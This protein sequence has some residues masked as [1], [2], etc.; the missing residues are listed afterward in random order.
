MN[1]KNLWSALCSGLAAATM[2]AAYVSLDVNPSAAAGCGPCGGAVQS[3]VGTGGGSTCTEAGQNAYN[4]A[5]AKAYAGA[6]QETPCQLTEG[7]VSSCIINDCYPGP[8]SPLYFASK[9][10]RFKTKSCTFP[11][12]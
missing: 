3:V 2:F 11:S 12:P 8:C 7:A 6:P 4:D 10:L 9:E 5:L 1:Q